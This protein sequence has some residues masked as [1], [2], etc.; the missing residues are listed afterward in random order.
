[1]IWALSVETS[2][3]ATAG[4]TP[5]R[6]I[7]RVRALSNIVA[8]TTSPSTGGPTP[9]ACER[10]SASCSSGWR[11]GAIRVPASAPN[12]VE[13]PYTGSRDCDALCTRARL[14]SIL[15]RAAAES[16]TFSPCRATAT[17]CSSSSEA[18]RSVTV[19]DTP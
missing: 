13:T 18:P 1:M 17:T 2:A 8:R 19:T 7:E 12:P 6:P 9:A 5:D 10:I 16:A 15:V 14:C 3:S 4:R 11:R